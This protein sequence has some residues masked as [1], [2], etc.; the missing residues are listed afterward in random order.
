MTRNLFLLFVRYFFVVQAFIVGVL[1]GDTLYYKLGAINALAIILISI[2]YHFFTAPID[3]SAKKADKKELPVEKE[4]K[5]A[6]KK[7]LDQPKPT[8]PLLNGTNKIV[9]TFT[10]PPKRRKRRGS[11]WAQIGIFMLTLLFALSV[12]FISREFLTYRSPVI[13][14][15]IGFIL[16]LLI[17]NIF[18]VRGFHQIRKLFTARIYYLL[19]LAAGSYTGLYLYGKGELVEHYL[20]PLRQFPFSSTS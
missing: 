1:T 19:L 20:P 16:F 14:V 3:P 11:F 5:K 12:H 8:Q 9:Q 15:V 4:E 18:E 6:D 10:P 2:C 17:G 13:A 7:E